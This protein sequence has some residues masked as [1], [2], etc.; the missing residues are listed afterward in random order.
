[1]LK[2]IQLLPYGILGRIQM[3]KES[4]IGV[5]SH[6]SHPSPSLLLTPQLGTL[7]SFCS[8]NIPHILLPYSLC[9]IAP[10]AWNTPLTLAPPG[11]GDLT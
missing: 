1:M 9:P 4:Y 11:H 3:P 5:I 7:G 10:H 8:L 6:F 2:N